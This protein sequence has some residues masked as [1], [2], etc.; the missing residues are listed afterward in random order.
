MEKVHQ[1]EGTPSWVSYLKQRNRQ[2]KNFLC[3]TAGTT[4]SGKSWANLSMAHMIDPTFNIDRVVFWGR[5]LMKLVDEGNLKSG[6][7]IMFDEASI[8]MDSRQWQSVTNKMVNYL[9][10]TFRYRRIIVLFNSPFIDFMDAKTRKLFHAEFQ[11]MGINHEKKYCSIKP[12]LLQYN[13]SKQ[14][15]YRKYLRV[16]TEEGYLP[17]KR[18]KVPQPPAKLIKEYEEK[19]EEFNRTLRKKIITELDKLERQKEKKTYQ[20]KCIYCDYAWEATKE[21][22]GRCPKCQKRDP[23]GQISLEKSVFEAKTGGNPYLP[24]ILT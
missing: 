14:K 24:P 3:F 4:G 5:D 17:V 19:K 10:Q 6:N 22:P 21:R 2:K 16:R 1:K 18:W 9:L 7:A 13:S 20:V 11:V 23:I 15:M 12:L 8:D